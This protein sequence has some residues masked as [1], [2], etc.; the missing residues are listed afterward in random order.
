M[1]G[2][3]R[4]LADGIS[5][6]HA[7]M[8]L[9]SAFTAATGVTFVVGYF[10]HLGYAESHVAAYGSVIGFAGFFSVLGSWLAQRRGDY[11][12]TMMLFYAATGAFCLAGVLTGAVGGLG[13][14]IPVIVLTLLAFFQLFIYMPAP[15]LLSWYHSIVGQ[16]KWQGFFS[17]RSIVADCAA[18]TTSLAVGAFLGKAPDTGR[19]LWVFTIAVLLVFTSV[20]TIY[21]VPSPGVTE[22]FPEAKEYFR[23]IIATMEKPEISRLLKI[24]F[25]RS[26]AYGLVLP[27]QPMFM[28]E[29][30]ELSYRD[31]SLLM[32]L[33]TL[34]SIFCYKIWARIQR[35]IGD[36]PSLKW[37]LLL[38]IFDPFLWALAALGNNLP[39]YLAFAV[40]G[41]SGWQG[42]INAGYWPSLLA[43]FLGFSEEH[44]KPIN[45][46]MY[47]FVYGIA[48]MIAAPIAGI[49]VKRFNIA[50]IEGLMY[51][52]NIIDGYRVLFILSGLVLVASAIYSMSVTRSIKQGCSKGGENDF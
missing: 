40:F 39:V 45:V 43:S 29:A 5:W 9:V 14:A 12:K 26:F 10:R 51:F 36:V 33:G 27:F 21:K 44:Q 25:L 50:P 46:A 19:F 23:T 37:N 48:V 47:F 13:K 17:T 35:R 42:I 28:L 2:R 7:Q 31:I 18:L 32:C 3:R 34:C 16:D 15:G 41:F 52:G 24:A 20:Y 11:K 8:G 30:L 4:V 38:S 6:S 49:L 1:P 22:E